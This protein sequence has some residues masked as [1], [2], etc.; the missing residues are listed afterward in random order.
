MKL[1]THENVNLYGGV[2]TCL[3]AYLLATVYAV[4]EDRYTIYLLCI[5]ETPE[6][7]TESE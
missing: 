3:L 1:L 4:L 7:V 2:I 5:S 6:T